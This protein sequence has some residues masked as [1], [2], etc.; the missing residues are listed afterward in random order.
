LF[1]CV[2]G[3]VC[4]NLGTL[5]YHCPSPYWVQINEIFVKFSK[6]TTLIAE[7]PLGPVPSGEYYI[8]DKRDAIRL[9]GKK[10]FKS[11]PPEI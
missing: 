10:Q 6:E 5:K 3:T 8:N 11:S 7:L 2:Y 9:N 4:H 1:V